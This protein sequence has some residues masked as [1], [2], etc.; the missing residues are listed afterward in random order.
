MKC[1]MVLILFILGVITFVSV[2]AQEADPPPN[3]IFITR[4]TEYAPLTPDG[5]ITHTLY[6]GSTCNVWMSGYF[7]ASQPLAVTIDILDKG[8]SVTGGKGAFTDTLNRKLKLIQFVYL[9]H[10]GNSQK[11]DYSFVWKINRGTAAIIR[12][13]PTYRLM[14]AALC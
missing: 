7:I 13:E 3:A 14:H 5:M 10:Q 1:L 11:H 4:S 8:V 6:V 12:V 2:L 9:V